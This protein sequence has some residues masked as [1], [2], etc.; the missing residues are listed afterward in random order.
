M[1]KGRE[2]QRGHSMSS[3]M[4]SNV[5]YEKITTIPCQEA[6][7][8]YETENNKYGMASHS[9]MFTEHEGKTYLLIYEQLI[10]L[11]QNRLNFTK[12]GNYIVWD[13]N[14]STV[15]ANMDQ[16]SGLIWNKISVP[17]SLYAR[18]QLY[19]TLTVNKE[20]YHQHTGKHVN[21]NLL[22]PHFSAM[23]SFLDY[24]MMGSI[25]GDLHMAH[26]SCM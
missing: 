10:D 16:V 21:S 12:D 20:L 3:K 5:L 23:F 6:E 8:I 2:K 11:N 4:E 24:V 13:V 26:V 15:I 7:S 9:M 18:Y 19:D 22:V 17:N 1:N 14:T 25:N